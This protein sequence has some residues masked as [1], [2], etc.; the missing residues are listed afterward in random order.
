MS[1]QAE[2]AVAPAIQ[3]GWENKFVGFGLFSDFLGGFCGF[4]FGF[5]SKCVSCTLFDIA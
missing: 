2:Q 5:F 4:V 3:N 1:G